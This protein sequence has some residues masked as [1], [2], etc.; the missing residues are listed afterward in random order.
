MSRFHSQHFSNKFECR[1]KTGK[2]QKEEGKEVVK[3]KKRQILEKVMENA[4]S[5]K[6]IIKYAMMKVVMWKMFIANSEAIIR[7]WTN[8]SVY[9]HLQ[10]VLGLLML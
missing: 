6:G 7:C 3:E 8:S 2:Q 10:T 9:R 4:Q 1:R 5:D